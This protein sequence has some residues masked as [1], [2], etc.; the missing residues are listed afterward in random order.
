MRTFLILA[1]YASRTVYQE[2][3]ENLS[4]SSLW[5]RNWL[6]LLK[7]FANHARIEVKLS[8]YEYWLRI[9]ALLGYEV[10]P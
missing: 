1:R 7:A 5:P 10:T 3:L 8:L 9:S 4:G 2:K 6:S